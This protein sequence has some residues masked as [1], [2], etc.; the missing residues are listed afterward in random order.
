MNGTEWNEMKWN[1]RTGN[2]LDN[3]QQLASFSMFPGDNTKPKWMINKNEN[4][5]ENGHNHYFVTTTLTLENGTI[6]IQGF[7][8]QV[9]AHLFIDQIYCNPTE[10]MVFNNVWIE[11]IWIGNGREKRVILLQLIL[12]THQDDLTMPLTFWCVSRTF[13]CLFQCRKRDYF[14]IFCRWLQSLNHA[15]IALLYANSKRLVVSVF[16]LD[17]ISWH[18]AYI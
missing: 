13:S 2:Q 7:P 17:S 3:V 14:S 9:F 11:E 12:R 1:E 16:H 10:C 15:R 6:A 8:M 18:N 5:S 4:L